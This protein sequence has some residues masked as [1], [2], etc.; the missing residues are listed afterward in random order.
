MSSLPAVETPRSDPWSDPRLRAPSAEVWA[1][2]SEAERTREE[3]RILGVLEEYR[4]A[5]AYQNQIEEAE[6][7]RQEAER[8]QR[9][10]VARLESA[11]A[12]L[13]DLLLRGLAERGLA[14]T[15]EQRARV[16]ACEDF[17]R[18]L[19]WAER[20]SSAPTTEDALSV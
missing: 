10:A 11:R 19:R 4:E 17:A 12:G 1:G 16:T 2:M 14:V 15:E 18:L 6:R 20:A 13:A 3:E 8:G 9:D 5:D 7:Q